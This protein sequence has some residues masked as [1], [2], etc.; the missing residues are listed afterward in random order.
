MWTKNETCGVRYVRILA[1]LAYITSSTS[2][3][4]TL[5][6]YQLQLPGAAKL[7]PNASDVGCAQG[8]RR[9]ARGDSGRACADGALEDAHSV[10]LDHGAEH[11]KCARVEVG[12]GF[13]VLADLGDEAAERL[14]RQRALLA[15]RLCVILSYAYAYA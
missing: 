5:Q 1:R 3:S 7:A 15:V 11:R 4:V 13:V 10:A 14:E 12:V 6:C 2:V 9:A 8:R